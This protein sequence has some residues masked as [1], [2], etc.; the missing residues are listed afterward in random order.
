MRLRIRTLFLTVALLC[1]LS[2]TAS[3]CC[4]IPLLDPFHWLFGCS[5]GYGPG[6]YCGPGYGYGQPYGHGY[7]NRGWHGGNPHAAQRTNFEPI[8][9]FH[10]A[11]L[12]SGHDVPFENAAFLARALAPTAG[13]ACGV[14]RSSTRRGRLRARDGN[15][16]AREDF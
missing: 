3:A 1:G 2:S 12:G 11:T 8:A 6:Q 10:V 15:L 7:G 5:S 13:R 16:S 4:F 9:A 14:S